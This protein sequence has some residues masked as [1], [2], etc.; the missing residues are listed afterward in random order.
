MALCHEHTPNKSFKLWIAVEE[1]S[2]GEMF[3][4]GGTR[5][6]PVRVCSDCGALFLWSGDHEKVEDEGDGGSTPAASS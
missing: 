5:R 2:F 6:A 1:T 4:I 3:G